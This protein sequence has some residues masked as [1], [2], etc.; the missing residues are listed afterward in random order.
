MKIV[1]D[2][3][4]TGLPI[5]GGFDKFY[6]PKD[7]DKYEPSRIIQMSWVVFDDDI[8]KQE[9]HIINQ[10]VKI[11][12]SHIHGI[13]EEMCDKGEK[14][15]DVLRIFEKDLQDCE[16][17]IGHNI[18]FDYLVLLSELH[19]HNYKNLYDIFENKRQFC[20]MR[21]S[22]FLKFKKLTHL[23]ETWFNDTF[24]AH[25]ALED[26]YATLRCYKWITTKTDWHHKIK[27]FRIN[28]N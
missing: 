10:S 21:Q 24:D 11:T 18:K 4:T 3:E 5:M 26:V 9:N 12:N 8:I 14:L 22:G 1:L 2:L 15:D 17:I 27:T 6:N 13:T 28:K 23:Y 16:L 19:R 7:L 25:D 20:T